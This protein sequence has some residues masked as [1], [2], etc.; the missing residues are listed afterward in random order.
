MASSWVSHRSGHPK[1]RRLSKDVCARYQQLLE[2]GRFREA[3]PE[4]LIFDT[5]GYGISFQHRMKAL[6]N[7]DP[8]KL[9]EHYGRPWVKFWIFPNQSRDIGPYLDQGFRRTAA[10]IMVGKPH[11]KDVGAGGK[12]L[13]AL[14]DG[15]RYGTPRFNRVMVPEVVDTVQVWPELDR[16]VQDVLAIQKATGITAAP[17]LA[18]L[19]QAA[20]TDHAVKIPSWLEGLRTGAHL[21]ET[22][23]RLL[24]RD[25]FHGGF[26]SQAKV[27][28][29]DQVYAVIVKCWNLHA[30]GKT[31]NPI[32]LRFRVNEL[33]PLVEGYTISSKK[34]RAA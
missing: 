13:A 34:G 3:T 18:V 26:I 31:I 5:E 10:H 6:A 9:I 21:S 12:Y 14:A 27:L 29:R 32:A 22:D 2:T 20:R 33:M 7:A 15:D 25:K 1:L 16:Y 19:A 11:A 23:P 8:A 17:H 30:T 4:G 24:L 28:R